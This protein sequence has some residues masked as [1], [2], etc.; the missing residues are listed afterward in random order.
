MNKLD[1]HQIYLTEK[2]ND[3]ESIVKRLNKID[4]VRS[5]DNFLN[6]YLAGKYGAFPNIKI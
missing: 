4:G 1:M 5:D 2:N 6:K 3:G